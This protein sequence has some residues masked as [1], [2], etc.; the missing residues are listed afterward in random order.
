M[1]P[2]ELVLSLQR[3]YIDVL[4]HI[5]KYNVVESKKCSN[6]G[7]LIILTCM[8]Q[9]WPIVYMLMGLVILTGLWLTEIGSCNGPLLGNILISIGD[10]HDN[11]KQSQ[12]PTELWQ[13]KK[14]SWDHFPGDHGCTPD[15]DNVAEIV[16]A[17]ANDFRALSCLNCDLLDLD[18]IFGSNRMQWEH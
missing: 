8:F 1:H 15:V 5:Q 13:C 12:N 17:C 2:G 18:S 14:L 10:V 4:L 7:L 6:L 11:S 3:N 9:W 16:S